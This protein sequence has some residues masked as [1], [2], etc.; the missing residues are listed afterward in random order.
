MQIYHFDPVTGMFAGTSDADESPLEP[1]I[2]LLPAHATDQPPPDVEEGEFAAWRDGKWGVVIA[3]APEP[4]PEPTPDELRQRHNASID[5]QIIAL[6][7]RQARAVRE[8]LIALASLGMGL[9]ATAA[10]RL[11]S[12]D[13]EIAALRGQRL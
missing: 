12:I 11:R 8:G 4:E 13:T 5:A 10:D 9:P 7:A 2:F 3:P 1:G 6:E